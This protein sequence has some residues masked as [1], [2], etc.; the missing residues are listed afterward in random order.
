[1]L[2]SIEFLQSVET[3]ESG[4]HRAFR[5]QS[6]EPKEEGPCRGCLRRYEWKEKRMVRGGKPVDRESRISRATLSNGL[7]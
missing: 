4:L 3:G 2:L 1:M 5:L 6:G 7:Y